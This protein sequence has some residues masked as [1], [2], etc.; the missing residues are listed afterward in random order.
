[1]RAIIAIAVDDQCQA[2]D[3]DQREQR[4]VANPK[5]RDQRRARLAERHENVAAEKNDQPEDEDCEAHA[6][7]ADRIAEAQPPQ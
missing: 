7:L 6:S 5:P 1:M 3:G 2:D 4:A